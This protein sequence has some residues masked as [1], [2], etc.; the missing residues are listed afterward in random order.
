MVESVQLV[1]SDR[2]S[3]QYGTLQVV[4]L[5]C[6]VIRLT[7]RCFPLLLLL[8][9]LLLLLLLLLLIAIIRLLLSMPLV[10]VI[11][12]HQPECVVQSCIL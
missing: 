1:A 2:D 12:E 6:V 7:Q 8:L 10:H 11:T 3:Y 5:T 9:I 4:I